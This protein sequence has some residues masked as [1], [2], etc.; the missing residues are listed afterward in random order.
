VKITEN[1]IFNEIDKNLYYGDALSDASKSIICLWSGGC[2]STLVLF[3]VLKFLKDKQD[4]RIVK[5]YS[6]NHA[7]L[8]TE[9]IVWERQKRNTFLLWLDQNGYAGMVQH[10]DISLPPY[11]ITSAGCPQPMLWISNIIHL[12]ELNSIILSGYHSGDDFWTYSVFSNWLKIATGLIN[13]HE[14]KVSFFMPYRWH[15][16][17]DIIKELKNNKIYDFTWW[18]EAPCS[19]G[20][21]GRCKPCVLHEMSH[22]Y[23]LKQQLKD[24]IS[25]PERKEKEE[26][27]HLAKQLKDDNVK[28]FTPEVI[29][30]EENKETRTKVKRDSDWYGFDLD[31]TLAVSIEGEHYDHTE[32]GEP[33]P[34]MIEL[35]KKYIDEGKTV[36][37]FTAR[38]ARR[39]ECPEVLHAIENWCLKH[40]GKILEITNEKTPGLREVFDDRAI[41]VQ[42]NTGNTINFLSDGGWKISV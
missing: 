6:F 37:I 8:D 38:Y 25:E 16:K 10:N 3:D 7:Q 41:S 9:K 31:G 39:F 21:C 20:K 33:V 13:G 2:D 23:Y 1:E 14:K 11:M 40:I 18:C 32:I 17:L 15:S 24:E 28:P 29:M 19:K 27:L 12:C 26:L 34:K 5:S 30:D 36:K 22:D 4:K 35:I 42:R